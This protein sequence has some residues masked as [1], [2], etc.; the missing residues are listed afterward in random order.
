MLEKLKLS[1]TDVASTA[2]NNISNQSNNGNAV[3]DAA[4]QELANK[5][6][7]LQDRQDQMF[8]LMDGIAVNKSAI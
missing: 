5:L 7:S 1:P 6:A 4:L 2:A 8:K 3:D